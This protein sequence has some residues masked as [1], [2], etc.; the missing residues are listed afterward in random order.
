MK[1]TLAVVI[2]CLSVLIINPALAECSYLNDYGTA[3]GCRSTCGDDSEVTSLCQCTDPA[4]NTDNPCLS[5]SECC[6]A[7]G[8][9]GG[10]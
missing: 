6:A 3:T 2:G 7:F 10:S 4:C 8:N 5:R 1:T 9:V